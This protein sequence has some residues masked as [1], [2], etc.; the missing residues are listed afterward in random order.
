MKP[1]ISIKEVKDSLAI[2]KKNDELYLKILSDAGISENDLLAGY[3]KNDPRG[4]SEDLGIFESC[5]VAALENNAE[6]INAIVST[7]NNYLLNPD[8]FTF[9]KF[10]LLSKYLEDNDLSLDTDLTL[11]WRALSE[12]GK[13]LPTCLAAFETLNTLVGNTDI[14]ADQYQEGLLTV[15]ACY[16]SLALD[17]EDVDREVNQ[18]IHTIGTNSDINGICIFDTEYGSGTHM[19]ACRRMLE[20]FTG[21]CL[22]VPDGADSEEDGYLDEVD[23]DE[24]SDQV[25]CN[26]G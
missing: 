10:A 1:I 9:W 19:S 17:H 13:D 23:W 2:Y 26:L 8:I 14:T 20:E 15:I 12:Y 18:L 4:E 6:K 22:E 3:Y 11:F 21:V 25:V 7:I 24:V 5:L 16:L